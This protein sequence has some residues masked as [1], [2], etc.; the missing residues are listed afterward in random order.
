MLSGQ[1]QLAGGRYRVE[2]VLSVNTGRDSARARELKAHWTEEA[3]RRL[4][5][6]SPGLFGYSLF[7][8][9]RAE[10]LKMRELQ[11]EYVRA[12]KALV[13]SS[14][15]NDCVGLYCVQLLDLAVDAENVLGSGAEDGSHEQLGAP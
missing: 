10:L 8:V 9:G 3:L 12:M 2:Q 14:G 15:R 13:Q 1:V 6:G 11:L 5:G 7:A 4:V